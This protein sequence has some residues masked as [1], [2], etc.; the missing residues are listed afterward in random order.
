MTSAI[1]PEILDQAI[2]WLVQLH[3]G[4]DAASTQAACQHWRAADPQ[5]EAAWQALQTTEACFRALAPLNPGAARQALERVDRQRLDRRQTLKLLGVIAM[6]AGAGWLTTSQLPWQRWRA[7][8]ATAIGERRTLLLADGTRVQ[9]D[10]NTAVNVQFDEQRHLLSLQ[11]GQIHIDSGADSGLPQGQRPFW[12]A[13]REALL[14][15]RAPQFVVRQDSAHSSLRV[16]TGQVVI[17]LPQ[18]SGLRVD[19]G[20]EYLI[21]SHGAQRVEH[22]PL[23]A[24]AWASGQLV[25]RQI[26]L[27]QLLEELSRYRHGWLRCDPAVAG[28]QVSGVFQLDDIDQVLSALSATLPVRIERTTPFWTHV[29]PA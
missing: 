12:V 9:L 20:Q 11:Q 3:A 5:H 26:R 15:A 19:A 7:D 18:Q 22:N 17:Q 1:A 25:V 4:D 24:S 28:L 6:T 10:T 27:G 8:Y 29:L 21:S 16:T 13:T 14:L 23:D 2:D